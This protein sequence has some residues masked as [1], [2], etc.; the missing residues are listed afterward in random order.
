MPLL[1]EPMFLERIY[2]TI[3]LILTF[4]VDTLEGIRTEFFFLCLKSWR[5]GLEVY[6]ATSCHISMVFDLVRIIISN[7]FCTVH[8][9]CKG[10]MVLF[11][12][13]FVLKNTRVYVCS[14]DSCNIAF[15]I[16]ASVNMAFSLR[17]TLSVLYINP[18]NCHAGLGRQFDYLR[19]RQ[20]NDIVKDVCRLNDFFNHIS[21]DKSG[22][23]FSKVRNVQDLKV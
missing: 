1:V 4:T 17:A 14:I 7:T 5:V 21:H 3:C 10:S 20:K 15:Y 13:V 8:V 9:V 16:K 22:Q 23:I 19:S 6:L 2:V 11:S 12:V 18:D